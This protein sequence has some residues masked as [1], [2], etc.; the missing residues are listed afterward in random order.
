MLLHH[1]RVP[2]V[3]E[4]ARNRWPEILPVLGIDVSF[5]RN[6]HGPC[7]ACGGKDR[8]RFDNK[9]GDGTYYCNQCGAGD[10]ITLVRKVNGWDFKTACDEIV[11]II[12]TTPTLP[13]TGAA[14]PRSRSP[15]AP[16]AA[17]P[18]RAG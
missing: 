3:V 8:F 11:R 4:R 2:Q 14:R 18:P 17:T 15:S 13:L 16:C 1:E 10:G 5:L 7:P 9:G 6:R 12:G